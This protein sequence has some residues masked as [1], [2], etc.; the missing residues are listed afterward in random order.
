MR[1]V[2]HVGVARRHQ[3]DRCRSRPEVVRQKIQVSNERSKRRKICPEQP[4]VR[5][6]FLTSTPVPQE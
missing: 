3:V 1:R 4:E 2:A 5:G 6:T